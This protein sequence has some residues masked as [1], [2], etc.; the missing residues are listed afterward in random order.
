[1]LMLAIVAVASR[2]RPAQSGGA[3]SGSSRDLIGY[4]AAA[5]AL[6]GLPLGALLVIWGLASRRR[7]QIIAPRTRGRGV[8]TYLLFSG[9]LASAVF[10]LTRAPRHVRPLRSVFG[11][12][13]TTGVR[14]PAGHGNGGSTHQAAAHDP[15]AAWAALFAIGIALVVSAVIV[16]VLVR[17]HRRELVDPGLL[18]AA[19]LAD[20][21]DDT[22]EDLRGERDPRRAVI[23]AYSR[24]ERTFAYYGFGREPFEAPFEYLA[25]ILSAQH[26]SGHSVRRLTLLF[27]RAKFSADQIDPQMKDDAIEALQALR[28]ELAAA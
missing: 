2:S 16:A 1:M 9:L 28:G 24:M 8:V 17:K 14:P 20:V 6:L 12:R 3:L 4:Y 5:F 25:R 23:A 27:E 22:L 11:R 10:L 13:Q 7:Q 21:L 26:A 18:V 19:A 15:R